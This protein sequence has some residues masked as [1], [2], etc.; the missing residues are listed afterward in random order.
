MIRFSVRTPFSVVKATKGARQ[1][2]SPS[3]G[4]LLCLE[5]D[6]QEQTAL[7]HR[8]TLP[9]CLG[10]CSSPGKVEA[11]TLASP[12]LSMLSA[13]RPASASIFNMA[14]TRANAPVFS[15][16]EKYQD[17]APQLLPA[18]NPAMSTW[19]VVKK[20]FVAG[21]TVRS[22]LCVRLFLHCSCPDAYQDF[23]PAAVVL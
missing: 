4:G 7:G 12:R 8:A 1:S 11:R 22:G 21:T 3:V 13:L 9:R 19:L 2:R 16:H 20:L 15:F 5:V 17:K 18:S 6:G 23:L 10:C 14:E